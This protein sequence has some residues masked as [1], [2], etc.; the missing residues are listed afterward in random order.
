[1]AKSIPRLLQGHKFPQ[2]N[3]KTVNIR[4]LIWRFSTKKFWS[5]P[6]GLKIKLRELHTYWRCGTWSESSTC[7]ILIEWPLCWKKIASINT[8]MQNLLNQIICLTKNH[9]LKTH[10]K[11]THY[12]YP[13]TEL[14]SNN[15]QP[16][17]LVSTIYL[18]HY[19]IIELS[20]NTSL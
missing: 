1:M 5:H 11:K 9:F 15:W 4:L 7:K 2:D 18:N 8:N 17:I 20:T 14:S 12:P 10:L 13:K 19:Y 3:S 16:Y 6:L